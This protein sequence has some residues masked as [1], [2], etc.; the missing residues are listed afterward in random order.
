MHAYEMH[1]A[2]LM[3]MVADAHNQRI[4]PGELGRRLAHEIGASI[5]VANEIIKQIIATGDLV[6]TYRDPCSFVELPLAAV[7]AGSGSFHR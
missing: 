3:E 4:R 6:Y 2:L 7:T 5:S 1:R